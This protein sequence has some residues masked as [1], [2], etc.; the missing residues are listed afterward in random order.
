MRLASAFSLVLIAAAASLARAQPP[1]SVQ[2]A[3]SIVAPI[4]SLVP[5]PPGSSPAPSPAP[6]PAAPVPAPTLSPTIVAAEAAELQTALRREVPRLLVLTPQMQQQWIARAQAELAA[7]GVLIDRPQLVVVVD[8]NPRVQE[9]CLILA[10]PGDVVWEV[11]GGA[12]VS[13]GQTGRFDHY[14]TPVGVFLHDGSILD[15]RAQGTF[16]ENHI[17]GLGLKGARV[18][19]FGWQWAAKGWRPDSGQIACCCMQRTRCWS[20]ASATRPR[21]AASASRRR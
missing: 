4:Y 15:Y 9:L 8:R 10:Q 5:M 19:D 14:I 21:M 11:I 6:A 3:P 17:R 12:H 18:W 13:T 16:N 2:T 7:H 20:R 1:A